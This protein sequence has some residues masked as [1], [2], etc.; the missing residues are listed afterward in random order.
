[1][2]GI[3]FFHNFID[4]LPEEVRSEM[5]E[6]ANLRTYTEGEQ[7]YRV[8]ENSNKLYKIESGT[9][10]L[11]NYSLHGKEITFGRL[12]VGDC[13]G[14]MGLIDNLCRVSSAIAEE[15]VR[16]YVIRQDDFMRLY[17]TYPEISRSL[18]VMLCNRLR[19]VT[20][21][22]EDASLLNLQQRLARTLIRLAISISTINENH[23]IEIDISQEELAHMLGASRQS[24]SKELQILSKEDLVEINYG[25]ISIINPQ[26]IRTRFGNL[27]GNTDVAPQ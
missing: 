25:R 20:T 17:E 11:C 14:E 26:E 27:M 2:Q 15:K 16:L 18:N 6:I 10:R 5:L 1:M 19:L 3:P 4:T 24:I 22:M 23:Q 8:G 13:F 9:V 21:L 12:E 7:I